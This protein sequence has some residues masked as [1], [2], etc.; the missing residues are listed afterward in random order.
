MKQIIL[1]KT[2]IKV[3]P[4]G[5]GTI[6]IT[7]LDWKESINL[8]HEVMDMGINLFDTARGYFDSELRLGDA[9]KSYRDKVVLIS[10]SDAKDSIKLKTNI[11]ETLQRLKTD[12]LDVFLFHG[13]EV[14]NQNDFCSPGGIMQ[15]AT[16]AVKAGK[17]RH[18]GFS[19]HRVDTAMKALT[20]NEL[21][22]AMVPANFMSLEYIDGDFQK[23]A[24][25]K[26]VAVIAMKPFGGGRI[27]NARV[28]L[29]FL[30]NYHNLI[31][32]IGIEKISEMSEN[33]KIWE[34][35]DPLSD[36]DRNEMARIR[37]LL[38]EKYCRGC[39][40]CMPCPEGI[41]IPSVTF[42]KVFAKQMPRDKVVNPENFKIVEKAETC[43]KCGKC[44]QK[45]P[46]DLDIPNMIEENIQ[47]YEE[48][49]NLVK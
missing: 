9:F 30:K 1:G 34:E 5:M 28:C 22:I 43:S 6:Q 46:F 12:Y 45:C 25:K 3:S 15:T 13:G 23:E 10:K 16:D 4:L 31:P 8:I 18:L 41:Q 21:K 39:G 27:V 48:F 2:G 14:V 20:Y 38:G 37:M 36:E 29:K 19:T 47:F 7:R 40:Y 33:I 44:I 49:S 42:L 24:V 11:D 26:G 35:K 17:I 32:C